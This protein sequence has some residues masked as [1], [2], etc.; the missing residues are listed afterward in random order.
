MSDKPTSRICPDCQ[1]DN[2]D[3]TRHI[4]LPAMPAD[5]G[6]PASATT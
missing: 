3:F 2:S 1:A 5:T 4:L 6:G